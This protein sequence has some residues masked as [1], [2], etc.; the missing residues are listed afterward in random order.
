MLLAEPAGR[1]LERTGN[2]ASRGM[3]VHDR[4]RL[5][6]QLHFVLEGQITRTDRQK[7][8]KLTKLKSRG[9]KVWRTTLF[10]FPD[11]FGIQSAIIRQGDPSPRH[12]VR[13]I[14]RS[15]SEKL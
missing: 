15:E 11:Q 8:T 2:R 12:S 10:P 1:L 3:I 13:L 7:N 14:S 9:S 6:G 5:I 4:T